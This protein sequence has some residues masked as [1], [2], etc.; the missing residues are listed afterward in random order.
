MASKDIEIELKFPLH[1]PDQVVGFLNSNAKEIVKN[2]FQKDTYYVPLHR[3]FLEYEYPY[4]WLRLRETDKGVKLTY[5][6][7]YP[8]N[9][10]KTDYCDE[11]QSEI[12]NGE[13]MKKIFENLD[14]KEIIV[15]EKNRDIWE[16]KDVEISIDNVKELG[17]Y[18]ELEAKGA[19]DDPKDGKNYLYSI[20][21]ELNT[22]LGEEDLRGYPFRMLEKKGYKFHS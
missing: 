4:E 11:F 7:F 1:N 17:Y 13:A 18:I 21:E 10:K 20:L 2:V 15:V 19:F 14:Y 3:D 22:E 12:E 16:Y 8:E 9:V 5:K 6:H